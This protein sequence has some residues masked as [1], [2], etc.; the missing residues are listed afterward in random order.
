ML[1]ALG[2]QSTDADGNRRAEGKPGVQVVAETVDLEQKVRGADRI[3][4]ITADETRSRTR[5]A[6]VLTHSLRQRPKP[7][8]APQ[9]VG[10]HVAQ[11][12]GDLLAGNGFVRGVF[13]LGDRL[14]VSAER[15]NDARS[16]GL[17]GE[18]LVGVPVLLLARGPV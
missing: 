5:F 13:V 9:A 16:E 14:E 2:A 11:R 4:A 18:G 15:G 12:A 8:G 3:I 10:D 7:V 6:T 17:V 1:T